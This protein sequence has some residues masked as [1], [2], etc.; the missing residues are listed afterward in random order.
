MAGTRA[1]TL[2]SAHRPTHVGGRVR[3]ARAGEVPRMYPCAGGRRVHVAL[4]AP[5][6]QPGPGVRAHQ[7]PAAQARHADQDCWRGRRPDANA[8]ASALPA[9]GHD[10]VRGLRERPDPPLE[11]EA[12]S[13]RHAVRVVVGLDPP[14]P[15]FFREGQAAGMDIAVLGEEIPAL[16]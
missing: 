10:P 12:D 1:G 3:G 16:G 15:A 6:T 4:L 13:R 5:P 2:P 9:S 7:A 8:R 11:P 14:G